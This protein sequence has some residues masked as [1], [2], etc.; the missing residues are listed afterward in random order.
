MPTVSVIVPNY[1]HLRHLPARLESI[2]AQTFRDFEVILL[3][4]AS[5]DG[6]RE[7]LE[8]QA[9]DLGARC[10]FSDTNSG[11]PF[12][13]WNRGLAMASGEYVWIAESDDWAEPGFLAEMVG[14]LTSDPA[15]M[16][17][18]C[19]SLAVDADG[20]ELPGR[21]PGLY[22][23]ER[24]QADF[25]ADGREE[26]ARYLVRQNT[27]PNA[28]AVVF[29]RQALL[30]AGGAEAGMRYCGDWITWARL[31]SR[32]RLSFC[33]RPLAWFRMHGGSLG[34]RSLG[35]GIF[36]RES[37]AVVAELLRDHAVEPDVRVQA[38]QA[39]V[40]A[41]M[42][43]CWENPREFF[44]RDSAMVRRT[45]RSVDPGFGVRCLKSALFTAWSS[46][47]RAG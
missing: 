37:A 3:D 19:R 30:D 24:W 6:S 44:S 16:L 11:S 7:W 23:T 45:L 34:S 31:V 25:T 18:Y 17:A 10:H 14:R 2:R 22:A 38:L 15:L 35:S 13:Q 42:A 33:A 20:R 40:G 9:G 29:R 12:H 43:H 4:D 46:M 47:R 39:R 26:C 5:T 28:S 21:L 32:G 41:W 36:H 8:A 27:I 1:N